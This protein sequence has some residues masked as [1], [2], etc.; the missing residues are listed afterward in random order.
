MN[1]I[2]PSALLCGSL[3]LA[4]SPAHA[5]EKDDLRTVTVTGN[6]IATAPADTAQ[7]TVGVV[8]EDDTARKAL[9]ENIDAMSEVVDQLKKEGISAKDIRT[10]NFSV[11]PRY[12]QSRDGK[13]P[14]I[15]GYRATNMVNITVRELSQLGDILDQVVTLGSNQISGVRF[16][17]DEPSKL[18]DEARKEAMKDA[19]RKA[20]L[21]AKA[22]GAS[23]G[24]ALKVQEN[25]GPQPRPMMTRVEARARDV[26]I[27]PG[28]QTL[29]AQVTVTWQMK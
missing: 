20:K 18:L 24:K 2:F 26:P 17:V 4:P 8:S 27:E 21:L 5:F 16:S 28:E 14:E 23:L 15:I 11:N 12:Q 6:G 7:I 10:L 1:R 25:Y 13:K 22:T 19:N 9:D 29:R 3:L